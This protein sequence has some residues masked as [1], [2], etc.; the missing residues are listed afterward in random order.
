MGRMHV[1]LCLCMVGGQEGWA[2]EVV[3]VGDLAVGKL[4]MQ[5]HH[6]PAW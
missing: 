1:W 2:V 4:Q 5:L 3:E 6:S